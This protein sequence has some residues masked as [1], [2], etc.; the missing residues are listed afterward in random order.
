MCWLAKP[1][2]PLKPCELRVVAGL[3]LYAT[4]RLGLEPELVH[5]ACRP[6]NHRRC[7]TPMIH[8]G[9]DIHKT[10]Y[11][12]CLKDEDGAILEEIR[13]RNSLEGADGLTAILKKYGEA[14]VALESTGNL[15]VKLYDRL[16]EEESIDVLLTNPKKTR[17]IAEAKIKTDKIDAKLL[18]DLVRADLVA[19]SYVPPKDI[20][21]QRALLRERI[22]LVESRTMIKNR[23]HALLDKYE[24]QSRYTD[25]F[26]KKGMKRLKNLNLPSID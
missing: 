24:I 14:K 3:R 5:V 16:D 17:V 11:Q 22:S 4:E 7:S 6:S 18:A 20:R 9:V 15:L 8:V 1:V 2:R 10:F 23:I 12:A 26:G 19:R 25:L 13:F 21:M